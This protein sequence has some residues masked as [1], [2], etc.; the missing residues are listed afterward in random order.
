LFTPIFFR[1]FSFLRAACDGIVI[2][3]PVTLSGS[4]RKRSTDSQ[5]GRRCRNFAEAVSALAHVRSLEVFVVNESGSSKE[6]MMTMSTM[7]RR[8]KAMQREKDSVAAALILSTY[9][10]SPGAAVRVRPPGK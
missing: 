3:L 4:L 1:F 10:E 8:G 9:F 6:A 2:G 5:Q 7:G